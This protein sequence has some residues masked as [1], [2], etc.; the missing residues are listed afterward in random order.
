MSKSSRRKKQMQKSLLQYNGHHFNSG[1]DRVVVQQPEKCLFEWLAGKY[2]IPM[3]RCNKNAELND[4]LRNLRVDHMEVKQIASGN[5]TII[6]QSIGLLEMIFWSNYDET[7]PLDDITFPSDSPLLVLFPTDCV[8]NGVEL[9][10]CLVDFN[11]DN[12]EFMKEH[13]GDYINLK[14]TRPGE[15]RVGVAFKGA[16]VKN[17]YD[18]VAL[19]MKKDIKKYLVSEQELLNSLDGS[20][21][22]HNLS[23]VR[24]PEH[25]NDSAMALYTALRVVLGLAVYLNVY[26]TKL[27]AVDPTLKDKVPSYNELSQFII[28]QP[29]W[30]N[31]CGSSPRAHW[32]NGTWVTY[33]NSRYKRNEDGTPKIGY[34]RPTWV[35]VDGNIDTAIQ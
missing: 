3:S 22:E 26:P 14:D 6:P 13:F 32:R 31:K 21:E 25:M 1:V 5:I 7:L 29:E 34:R 24:N 19:L 12:I 2:N 30:I 23:Y 18:A 27:T 8:I 20:S 4:V 15:K 17:D 9:K 28:E 10:S 16:K 33:K 35:S 11:C